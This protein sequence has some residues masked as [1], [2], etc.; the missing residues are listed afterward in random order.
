MKKGKLCFRG[1]SKEEYVDAFYSGECFVGQGLSGNGIYLTTDSDEA[2]TNYSNGMIENVAICLLDENMRIAG[3]QEKKEYE[4]L[5][6][7]YYGNK[8]L[9]I[10][11]KGNRAELDE[12]Y[13]IRR[14][15]TY[16]IYLALKGYDG[17]AGM[18]STHI[19]LLNRGKV[20]VGDNP[21]EIKRFFVK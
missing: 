12:F 6:S 9:E 21:N 17:Y 15:M 16:P 2:Y 8:M 14:E 1:M 4:A 3:A 19:V 13:D 5:M 18:K 20:K 10:K 11:N 7:S